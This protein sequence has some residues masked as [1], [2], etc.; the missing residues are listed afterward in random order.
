MPR[1]TKLKDGFK[2][3]DKPVKVER[4]G[5]GGIRWACP[6]CDVFHDD[7]ARMPRTWWNH[8]KPPE[9]RTCRKVVRDS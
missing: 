7:N 6:D 3:C 2:V 9:G 8:S 1:K 4:H 5:L